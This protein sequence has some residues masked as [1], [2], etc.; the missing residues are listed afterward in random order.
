MKFVN[1]SWIKVQRSKLALIHFLT[2]YIIDNSKCHLQFSRVQLPQ[3]LVVP[4]KLHNFLFFSKMV[5]SFSHYGISLS[6]FTLLHH[7]SSAW[8]LLACFSLNATVSMSKLFI[9]MKQESNEIATDL[10]HLWK[11]ER[12]EKRNIESSASCLISSISTVLN[13]IVFVAFSVWY[14]SS[15]IFLQIF[16]TCKKNKVLVADHIS[17]NIFN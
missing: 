3:K 11:I 9:T 17:A 10:L 4:G 16:L 1:L 14:L 12:K 2:L 7:H 5:L 13:K 6:F 8:Y 15:D